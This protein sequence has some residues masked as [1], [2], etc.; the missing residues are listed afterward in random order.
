[1]CARRQAAPLLS[2]LAEKLGKVRLCDCRCSCDRV[3]SSQRGRGR[4]KR[5]AV[6]ARVHAYH[7][8]GEGAKRSFSVV[9]V[10]CYV[11]RECLGTPFLRPQDF[12]D[13]PGLAIEGALT[14]ALAAAAAAE[15]IPLDDLSCVR[16]YSA[17]CPVGV[18]FAHSRGVVTHDDAWF[19]VRLE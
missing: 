1:M 15:D 7:G 6:L 12:P 4:C 8:P 9:G 13:A 5:G 19:A 2:G 14:N 10:K 3:E 16:D 11:A 18:C 17:A